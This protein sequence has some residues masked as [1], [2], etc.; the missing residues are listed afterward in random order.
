MGI[1]IWEVVVKSWAVKF[2]RW[3]LSHRQWNFGGVGY[4]IGSGICEVVAKSL[5]VE[6]G[7]WWLSQR[8]WNLEGGG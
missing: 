7:R 2:W 4:F 5:A 6:F 8:Q 3:W 1:G